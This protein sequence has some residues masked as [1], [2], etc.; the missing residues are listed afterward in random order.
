MQRRAS[1]RGRMPSPTTTSASMRLRRWKSSRRRPPRGHPTPLGIPSVPAAASQQWASVCP[2]WT[3]SGTP[4]ALFASIARSRSTPRRALWRRTRC[5]TMK[6]ASTSLTSRKQPV[7]T[8]MPVGGS[9]AANRDLCACVLAA[10]RT[11]SASACLPWRRS[12]TQSALSA[13]TAGSRSTLTRALL[14]WTRLRTTMPAW[15][16]WMKSVP[17]R[18]RS[19][20]RRSVWQKLQHAVGVAN[21]W[22]GSG[23]PL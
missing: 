12:G 17:R 16:S 23:C 6:S 5:R 8:S 20:C 1:W 13:D 15:T 21:R 9:T 11:S 4:S 14:R 7:G 10:G 22:L 2:P 18:R 19:V 3:R